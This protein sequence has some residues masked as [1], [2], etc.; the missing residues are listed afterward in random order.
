MKILIKQ[1][2]GKEP[3]FEINGVSFQFNYDDIKKYIDLILSTDGKIEFVN[4]DETN[5]YQKLLNEIYNGVNS[6]D[7]KLAVEN[8]K[9]SKEDLLF[10]EEKHE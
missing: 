9:K 6:D 10:A 7:F 5:Q 3:R 2:S 8:A 4:N 1:E